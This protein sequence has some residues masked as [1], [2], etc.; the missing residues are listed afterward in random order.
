MVMVPMVVLPMVRVV[1]VVS[2][3]VGLVVPAHVHQHATG[4]VPH[5]IEKLSVEVELVHRLVIVVLTVLPAHSGQNVPQRALPSR[6]SSLVTRQGDFELVELGEGGE[7]ELPVVVD[8][9]EVGLALLERVLHP[10]VPDRLVQLDEGSVLEQRH[11]EVDP[12]GLEAVGEV[13][14]VVDGEL[15]LELLEAAGDELG[16]LARQEED[17]AQVGVRVGELHC[18]DVHF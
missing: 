18:G 6:A 13:V 14:P 12:E 4:I 17:E 7:E 8:P 2:L 15:G 5:D 10:Q 3:S 16:L 1:P 9:P 11:L